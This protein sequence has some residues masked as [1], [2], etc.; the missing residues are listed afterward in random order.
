MNNW[1]STKDLT[2][3]VHEEVLLYMPAIDDELMESSFFIGYI[4]SD[5][6]YYINNFH[7]NFEAVKYKYITHWIWLPEPPKE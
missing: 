7:N 1:I 5:G 6:N 3:P 4:E 2:P